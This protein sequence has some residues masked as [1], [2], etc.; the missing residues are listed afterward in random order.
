MTIESPDVKNFLIELYT[1]TEGDVTQQVSMYDIGEKLGM[2]KSTISTMSE[3]LII[4]QLVELKTLSGGI[5]ITAE[6]IA[7]LQNDGLISVRPANDAPR[8]SKGPVLDEND[9]KTVD[10]LLLNIK[11]T[12]YGSE[13]NYGQLEELIIDIKTINTQ[14]LS[15][16]PKLS[17]IKEVFRSVHHTLKE[18]K[19]QDI[20]KK[21]KI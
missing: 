21:L 20:V 10:Q 16:R 17:I 12:V 13:A 2:E 8:L 19:I 14:L 5:G 1:I 9:I 15:P 7:A 6:G 11:E 3:N 18:L 4:D